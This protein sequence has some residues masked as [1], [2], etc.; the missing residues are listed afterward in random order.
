MT[1]NFK[2]AQI[3]NRPANDYLTCRGFNMAREFEAGIQGLLLAIASG[4]LESLIFAQKTDSCNLF[5]WKKFETTTMQNAKD[6][7]WSAPFLENLLNQISS[8][9]ADINTYNKA[10]KTNAED[11]S[12]QILTMSCYL[13]SIFES[14]DE[15][16]IL[17][18]FPKLSETLNLKIKIHSDTEPQRYYYNK[19]SNYLRISLLK[20]NN[21]SYCILYKSSP[22]NYYKDR[23]MNKKKI[24][25]SQIESLITEAL[26]FTDSCQLTLEEI[27]KIKSIYSDLRK[28]SPKLYD[29]EEKLMK[30][31]NFYLVYNTKCASC[32]NKTWFQ[33]NCGCFMCQSCGKNHY[34]MSQCS[35]CNAV[36]TSRDM[37]IIQKMQ[38]N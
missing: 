8:G 18:F 21:G 16:T 23:Q 20:K 2:L 17:S 29:F 19:D 25:M 13:L 28:M 37:E 34:L 30:A 14:V 24:N 5:Y 31:C 4:I 33:L 22:E 7:G 12:N 3:L 35:T 9:T 1:E 27:E 15:E 36:L 38:S 26:S 11:E 32:S 10:V 6:S